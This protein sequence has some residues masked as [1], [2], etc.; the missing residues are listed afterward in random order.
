[1]KNSEYI[2]ASTQAL[3]GFQMIEEA[4]KLCIGLSYEIIQ[5][6]AAKPVS[7]TFNPDV[8]LNAPLGKLT[9]MYEGV[10]SQQELVTH[11][12][13]SAK[14]RNF[15]AHNAF[16]HELYSRNGKS[17]YSEHSVEDISQVV[18]VT[19]ELTEEIA[20]EIVELQKKYKELAGKEYVP[21]IYSPT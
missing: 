4:L 13:K 2:Q 8:I 9:S 17:P 21:E 10:T 5:L 3:L 11:L 14:W 15:L 1:M 19:K 6:S 12:R 18:K 7:F 16:R 20:K